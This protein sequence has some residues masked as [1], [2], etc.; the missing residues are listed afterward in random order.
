MSAWLWLA[1]VLLCWGLFTFF[2][3]TRYRHG[4]WVAFLLP[5]FPLLLLGLSLLL[6]RLLIYPLYCLHGRRAD[7]PALRQKIRSAFGL[8]WD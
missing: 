3:D 4:R 2:S 8:R 1:I 5:L 6:A 7:Y